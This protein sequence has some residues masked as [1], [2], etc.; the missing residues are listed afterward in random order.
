M[1]DFPCAGVYTVP[2][3]E[4]NFYM[5]P[6]WVPKTFGAGKLWPSA[7]K[8]MMM[9]LDC[10]HCCLIIQFQVLGNPSL[11][12]GPCMSMSPGDFFNA[13]QPFPD[14]CFPLR[15]YQNLGAIVAQVCGSA[16]HACGCSPNE[17]GGIKWLT[18]FPPCAAGGQPPV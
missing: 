17:S 7:S 16:Q 12:V 9:C 14:S 11:C 4:S 1:F 8:R 2:L 10:I 3:I 5:V 6:S 15:D 13:N 18:H